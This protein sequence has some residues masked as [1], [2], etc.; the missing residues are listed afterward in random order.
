MTLIQIFITVTAISFG[1]MYAKFYNKVLRDLFQSSF[2]LMSPLQF[3]DYVLTQRIT[4]WRLQNEI[5]QQTRKYSTLMN[6]DSK[7]GNAMNIAHFWEWSVDHFQT[8]RHVQ[9]RVLP[10]TN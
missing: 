4:R 8:W 7:D 10:G 9:S 2:D 1:F 5:E 3:K 6:P